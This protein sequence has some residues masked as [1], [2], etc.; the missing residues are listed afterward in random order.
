MNKSISFISLKSAISK[1][2]FAKFTDCEL[3]GK[4]INGTTCVLKQTV[5]L[6]LV[7]HLTFIFLT[8]ATLEF[9]FSKV[10]M[11]IIIGI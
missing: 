1:L 7:F 6:V 11:L 8:T 2:F 10:K 9:S 5:S 4:Q 3:I